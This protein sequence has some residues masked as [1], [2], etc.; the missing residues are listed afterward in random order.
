MLADLDLSEPATVAEVIVH[1]IRS[2]TRGMKC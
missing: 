1:G 2:T